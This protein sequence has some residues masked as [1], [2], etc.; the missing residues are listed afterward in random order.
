MTIGRGD[1]AR[2]PRRDGARGRRRRRGCSAHGVL[3][4][5]IPPLWESRPED[6]PLAGEVLDAR[7]RGSI[8]H[9]R[10][11]ERRARAARLRRGRSGGSRIRPGR[12]PRRRA[13]AG[14]R[15]SPLIGCFG[16]L[17]ASKRDPA[18]ARGVRARSARDA[19]G[20]AAA[21]R[22]RRGAR[23]RPRPAARSGSGSTATARPRGLRR[24]GA[25]LVA[26]GRLRRL[27]QPALAD[28]GRDVRHGDP[29]A[30][31][32][33][34]AGRLR[35]RLVR[36]AA[37]RRRAEGAGRR[38]R[39]RRRS[40]RRSSCSRRGEDARAAMG[41]AARRSRGAST[42]SSRVAELLRGG[43]R[44]G[45]RR[46]A[47]SPTPCSARS[48]APRPRSGSSP[49]SPE[50]ARA[51]APARR[52]RAWSYDAAAA[53]VPAVGAGSRRSS[54]SRSLVR[55]LAR[56]R[57]GRAVDHG[58]R[59]DLLRARA[60][61]RR[62]RRAP[63]PRRAAGGYGFVYPVADQPGLRALRRA[64]DAYAA[65]KTINALLMSLAAVPAYFLA[66]RVRRPLARARSPRRSRVACPRCSTPAR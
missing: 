53:A 20:G 17:N 50:A 40:R 45:R 12:A 9:S 25:A 64:A 52:G 26:D 54:S 16:N 32:R 28:D 4:K 22:R 37:G 21:A 11:V 33:Q 48:R 31:A 39:G 66:R 38:G 10:Y 2:L 19:P 62:R 1:G 42:T 43:A 8:V 29:R 18:A 24:R 35:R 5:R 44:G 65:V 30:L 14:R 59:A 3:D 49:A 51:R 36:R 60:E 41:A 23:L 55:G 61:L 57:D 58:R 6:F 15:A 13:G 56:A 63:R 27:R 34:A 47:P 46:R 7:A